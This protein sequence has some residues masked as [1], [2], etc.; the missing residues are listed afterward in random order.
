MSPPCPKP[1]FISHPHTPPGHGVWG[2]PGHPGKLFDL[3]LGSS[4]T[5][6]SPGSACPQELLLRAP[7]TSTHASRAQAFPQLLSWLPG[8]NHI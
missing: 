2:R 5:E 8:P 1:P 6:P 3:P 4:P 7:R